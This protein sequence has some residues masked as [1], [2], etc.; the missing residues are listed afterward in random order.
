MTVVMGDSVQRY[1]LLRLLFFYVCGLGLADVCYSYW[2][3][4]TWWS[5]GILVVILFLVAMLWR[6]VLSSVA[7]SALFLLLGV[8]CYGMARSENDFD[9]SQQ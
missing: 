5:I 7:L 6:K 4:R 2:V 8:W 1:P 9:W 3:I